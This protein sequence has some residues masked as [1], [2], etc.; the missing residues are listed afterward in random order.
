MYEWR[1]ESQTPVTRDQIGLYFLL[2]FIDWFL[3]FVHDRVAPRNLYYGSN[4]DY[5]IK[6]HK[7]LNSSII[8]RTALS[9]ALCKIYLNYDSKCRLFLSDM[10]P[11]KSIV[12]Q[13]YDTICYFEKISN[14]YWSIFIYIYYTSARLYSPMKCFEWLLSST[15][16][17]H[18][19]GQFPG[20]CHDIGYL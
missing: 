10:G 15:H 2:L 3:I 14:L 4:Q 7:E 19:P 9:T 20:K 1:H 18:T 17:W 8:Q 12:W 13:V 11:K 16:L 5:I 6:S